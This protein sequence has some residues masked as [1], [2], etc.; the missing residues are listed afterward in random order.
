M[1]L[2]RIEFADS[3]LSQYLVAYTP[4]HMQL[5]TVAPL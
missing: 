3:P 2:L 5:R 1:D 4:N